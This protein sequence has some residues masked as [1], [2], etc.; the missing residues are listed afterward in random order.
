MAKLGVFGTGGLSLEVLDLITDIYKTTNFNIDESVFFIDTLNK[1]EFHQ[2]LKIVTPDEVDFSITEIIMAIGDSNMREKIVDSL[3]KEA[4]YANL[5]HPSSYVSP[6]ARLGTDVIISHCCVVSSNVSVGSHSLL[7]YHTGIG[8]ETVLNDFFTSAPGVKISG[9]CRIGK[10][11]SFGTNAC[12][13][14]G[15]KVEDKIKVGIGSV[16]MNNLLKP[17]TYMFNPS[18]KILFNLFKSC[19]LSLATDI[20]FFF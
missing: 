19:H 3:P 6:S 7:N 2:G 20:L 11:V 4:T 15:I 14:Q 13:V 17:G 18:K 16:V 9:N 5:I 1:N 10:N 8:H 12:C